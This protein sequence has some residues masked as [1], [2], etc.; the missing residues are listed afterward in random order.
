MNFFNKNIS[1]ITILT[2]FIDISIY[3]PLSCIEHN[4]SFWIHK[5]IGD[6]VFGTGARTGIFMKNIRNAKHSGN[7]SPYD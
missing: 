5:E 7:L 2:N 1:I 4:T 6:T 3:T